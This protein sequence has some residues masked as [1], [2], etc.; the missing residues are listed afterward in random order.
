MRVFIVN[1][2]LLGLISSA[3]TAYANTHPA[4]EVLRAFLHC[5]AQFLTALAQ[6]ASQLPAL[7]PL[8]RTPTGHT[9]LAV[10][11]RLD[12]EG[13]TLALKPPFKVDGVDFEEFLDEVTELQA[14]QNTVY[15][16]G[17]TSQQSLEKV[18]PLVQ[19]LLPKNAQLTAD[20]QTWARIDVFEA[21]AWRNVPHHASLKGQPATR[22][23]R[24]L[25][26]QTNEDS[27]T[28]V[29]CGLQAAPLPA[30]E[31]K[32]LRPDLSR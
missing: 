7:R 15:Y 30:A 27:G 4:H 11:N 21:G 8:K 23:E 22:P 25:I 2:A 31:L 20:E 6:H 32:R 17:F 5:D 10:P 26:V 16:W 9:Y 12:E 29:I 24:A 14:Q 28:R 13:Q 19:S 18:L 3:H 1:L